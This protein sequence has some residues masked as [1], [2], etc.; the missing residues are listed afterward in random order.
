[1]NAW[2]KSV[3][4]IPQKLETSKYKNQFSHENLNAKTKTK[5]IHHLITCK[6]PEHLIE[7]D[8]PEDQV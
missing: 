6:L 7:I 4:N 2:H 5:I 1:M 8:E 3:Q